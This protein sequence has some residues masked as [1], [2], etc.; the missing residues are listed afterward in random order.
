MVS[1]G[2]SKLCAC[3]VIRDDADGAECGTAKP[4]R[5]ASFWCRV[6]RVI[7]KGDGRCGIWSATARS[8]PRAATAEYGRRFSC[9]EGFRD[10]KR[11]LGFAEARI[12]CLQAWQRMFTLVAIALL[13]MTAMGCQMIKHHQLADQLLRRVRSRRRSRS[14][15]SMVR[16]IAELLD[17]QISLWE[18]LCWSDKLNLEAKL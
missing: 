13:V 14:E 3:V 11:L 1:G 12:S 6:E 18:L 2:S 16:A 10:S 17:K 8:R 4:T 5:A 15:L 9:E 7:E